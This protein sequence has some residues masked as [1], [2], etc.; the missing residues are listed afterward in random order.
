MR[1]QINTPRFLLNTLD[2]HSDFDR[3]SS[4]HA[5][6]KSA[7][8]SITSERERLKLQLDHEPC[9]P[10]SPQVVGLKNAL[11]TVREAT[12][13]QTLS[14][15]KCPNIR[16]RFHFESDVGSPQMPFPPTPLT[17]SASP[18]QGRLAA[19]LVPTHLIPFIQS[20]AW[21]SAI[22]R[23]PLMLC[24]LLPL[25]GDIRCSNTP[26]QS[27]RGRSC[28]FPVSVITD[29]TV[30]ALVSWGENTFDTGYLS[31]SVISP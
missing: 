10:T 12:L 21:F 20:L 30:K 3:F 5:T 4:V 13:M 22:I 6:M 2:Q 18:S 8:S 1:K 31:I 23:K 9:P 27:V 11:A 24:Q 14:K 25:N 7:L 19:E 26:L 17:T 29:L 15:T 16:H 28:G